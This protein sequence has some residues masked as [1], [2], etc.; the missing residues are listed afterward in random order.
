MAGDAALRLRELLAAGAEVPYEVRESGS[1][2]PLAEYVP[3]TSRFIRDH[4]GELTV[5]DSFGTTCAA[6]ESAELAGPYLK[7]MGV[8]DPNDPRRRAEL[9]GI[10]FL[11]RLWQGS[12]DFTLDDTRLKATME[13]L[14]ELGEVTRDEVEIAVP[15]R[16]F[17]MDAERLE[18]TGAMIVRS[19]V[20]DVPSEA[21]GAEGMGAAAWEPS[22]LAVARID[23]VGADDDGS[24]LGLR[25]VNAF[26]RVITTLR[27]F[28]AG[29]VA[30]GPHAWI[31]SGGD[32]WRRIATGAG[33]PRPG[34]Y[35]LASTEVRDLQSFSQRLAAEGAPFLRI[36][37]D[38]DGFPASLGRAISRFEAGL[39]RPVTVE[40]LSDYLLTLRFLLEGGGPASLGMSMRVAALCAAPDDRTQVKE[41]IDR[42]LA[43]ERELW[44]GEPS[45]GPARRPP[46]EIAAEVED[47]TRAILG[48]AACGHL[49]TELRITADE[50]LLGD[51]LRVG[52][53]GAP[54]TRGET[55]E[56]DPDGA[57]EPGFEVELTEELDSYV[58]A[59]QEP[60]EEREPVAGFLRVENRL[61]EHLA[62]DADFE[63]QDEPAP[64]AERQRIEGPEEQRLADVHVLRTRSGDESPVDD[65]IADS[66]EHRRQVHARVSFLFPAPETTEWQVREVGYDRTR[67]AE[68]DDPV[69]SAS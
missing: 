46:A 17:Q 40:A 69:T 35:R 4:G 6:M 68:V 36:E 11:C 48:D 44:S 63:W 58:D 61:H 8:P 32:R 10:V 12:T 49:G 60:A 50:I 22:F 39:E 43:V 1:S 57:I 29:G 64:T 55:A 7:E 14:F 5:L 25:S 54:D 62:S 19:D 15:L 56:W 24:D 26:K 42:A 66:D 38:R 28:K 13:E 2:S 34:G 59:E 9:A 52:E 21:R 31:R 30:L 37:G 47:L 20:V 65:L 51:G 18:L 41:T 27:M 33:K 16:G 23:G 67:R 45:M 53:G 3:Q